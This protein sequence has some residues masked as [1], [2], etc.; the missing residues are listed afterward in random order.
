MT[1]KISTNDDY[2][3]THTNI[4]EGANITLSHTENPTTTIVGLSP[5]FSKRVDNAE[6]TLNE[7][8]QELVTVKSDITSLG[9]SKQDKLTA[10]VGIELS[11]NNL[12][13]KHI[14]GYKGDL[15]ALT[16][17][18]IVKPQDNCPNL[19]NF[20]GVYGNGILQVTRVGDV[21]IQV[22]TTFNNKGPFI[23]SG[24]NLAKTPQWYDWKNLYQDIPDVSKY[25]LKTDIPQRYSVTA[26]S[27]SH[28]DLS[29]YTLPSSITTVDTWYG[30][31]ITNHPILDVVFETTNTA[32]GETQQYESRALYRITDTNKIEINT[33][34]ITSKALSE[35]LTKVLSFTTL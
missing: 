15:N 24:R 22:Y 3:V 26:S 7:A 29:N 2:V 28:L 17:T 25:A 34:M 1:T 4:R 9:T 12:S 30:K 8:K 6:L 11:G 13:L 32:T 20:Q 21:V 16:N 31:A 23:R 14:D 27:G 10:S 19:P 35:N 5:I 33:H 18:I